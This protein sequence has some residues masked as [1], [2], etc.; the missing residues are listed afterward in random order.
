MN[1]KHKEIMQQFKNLRLKIEQLK[2]GNKK[3]IATTDYIEILL[4]YDK[5]KNEKQVLESLNYLSIFID[6]W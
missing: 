3:K 1:K 6:N 4:D 2:F 5:N